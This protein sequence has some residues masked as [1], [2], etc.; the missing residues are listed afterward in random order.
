MLSVSKNLVHFIK[1]GNYY[2][3][4]FACFLPDRK[5]DEKKDGDYTNGGGDHTKD[6]SQNFEFC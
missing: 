2:P 3:P 4:S 1:L 5:T 6:G